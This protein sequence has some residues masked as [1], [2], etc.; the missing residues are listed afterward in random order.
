VTQVV[1]TTHSDTLVSELT[2]EADS[3]LVCEHVGGSTEI[4]RLESTKLQFW[5]EQYRLGEVWRIG[6]LGGNPL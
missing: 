2:D 4:H 6:K 1:V 3:V 5:L